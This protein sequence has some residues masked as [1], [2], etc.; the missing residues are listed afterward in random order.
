MILTEI[1]P[2]GVITWKKSLMI[3]STGGSVQGHIRQ[4]G[5]GNNGGPWDGSGWNQVRRRYGKHLLAL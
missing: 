2:I 4:Y 3:F 1:M 5:P